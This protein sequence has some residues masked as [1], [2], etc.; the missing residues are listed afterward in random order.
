MITFLSITIVASVL[1][2]FY[3]WALSLLE[4]RRRVAALLSALG[5]SAGAVIWSI[6]SHVLKALVYGGVVGLLAA[7]GLM[8]VF[9]AVVFGIDRPVMLAA[10]IATINFV[11]VVITI[12]AA[13]VR[14]RRVSHRLIDE[15][16]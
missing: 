3:A 1:T 4:E 14:L 7:V 8:Q 6:G 13:L 9:S 12:G 16:R 15:L 5:A 11:V 2:T 10:G